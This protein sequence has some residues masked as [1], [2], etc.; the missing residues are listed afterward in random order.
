MAGRL[1]HFAYAA[2]WKKFE[3]LWNSLIR[4]KQVGSMLPVLE[5]ILE[6]FGKQETSESA[7]RPSLHYSGIQNYRRVPR[8]KE[9]WS[10]SLSA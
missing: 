5:S 4:A 3:F 10:R 6:E 8:A 7:E 9:N 1:R 2:G